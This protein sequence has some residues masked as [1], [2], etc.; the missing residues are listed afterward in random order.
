MQRAKEL[1]VN[2][3]VLLEEKSQDQDN[4]RNKERLRHTFHLQV[5]GL[6]NVEQIVALGNFKLVFIPVLVDESNVQPGSPDISPI[7]Q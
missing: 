5:I 2:N 7:F 1:C 6:C 4:T 3:V